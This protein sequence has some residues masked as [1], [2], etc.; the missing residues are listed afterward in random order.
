MSSDLRSTNFLVSTDLDGTL[1]DHHTYDWHAAKPAIE[2]LQENNIP[3]IFNTS[4]TLEEARQ[5]Q[6]KTG[7][8]APV[9][10]ENGSA[11]AIKADLLEVIAPELNIDSLRRIDGHYLVSFGCD[12]QDI[13]SFI[14]D[15]KRK[16]GDILEG[17]NDW[18]VED[19]ARLTGLSREEASI[20]ARKYYSEPFIWRGDEQSY[21]SFKCAAQDGSFKILQGGRFFH[22]QGPTD[23]GKP[24]I[25]LRE[26]YQALNNNKLP[27][28]LICLGDNKNDIDMLNV[29]DIAVCVKSPVA[30]Y[31][32]I[33][34][35]ETTVFTKKYGPEGWN[36]AI[37]E[38]LP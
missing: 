18:S 9:I 30:P 21:A 6:L 36:E 24:L 35:T 13:L 11:V 26:K 16:L 1:L 32:Q 31:P 33:N 5:L 25:W 3:I 22:L 8:E 20:S 2:A 27:P 34:K 7:I 38:I 14:S 28:T 29:A 17:Y 19:I 4:K 12:R 23:K 10:I 37:S 15:Q